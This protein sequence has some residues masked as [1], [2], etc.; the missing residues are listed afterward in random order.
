MV[1]E[2]RHHAIVREAPWVVRPVPVMAA[3]GARAAVDRAQARSER[4]QPQRLLA[5]FGE[6]SNGGAGG[7]AAQLMTE[8]P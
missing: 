2:C 4:S 1:D 8:R 5:V 7:I 3:S 6:R